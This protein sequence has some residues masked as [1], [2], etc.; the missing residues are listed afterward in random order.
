LTGAVPLSKVE[1]GWR[2]GPE[3]IAV[4]AAIP[5]LIPIGIRGAQGVRLVRV[6]VIVAEG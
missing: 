2:F 1:L 5:C 6:G 4:F 3:V